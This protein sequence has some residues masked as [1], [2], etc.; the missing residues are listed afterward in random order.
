M[1]GRKRERQQDEAAPEGRYGWMTAAGAESPPPARWAP[2]TEAGTPAVDTQPDERG[3]DGRG[4]DEPGS[5]ERGQ[6]TPFWKRDLSLGRKPAAP[7]PERKRRGRKEERGDETDRTPFWKR[8][9]SLVRTRRADADADAPAP[10]RRPKRRRHEQPSKGARRHKQLV[11][12]K[13]GGSQLAAARVVNNGGVEVTQLAREALEPGVIVGGEVRDPEALAEALKE[14]FDRHKLPKRN[15]RLGL[16]NNRIG[17]RTLEIVG[18]EDPKQ[19][20]NAIRFR[21]QEVLPIAIE[22][23]VLDYQVL[24]EST[25]DGESVRR[26]LLVV[27]YR[28]LVDRYVDACRRAGLRLAGIDLEAFALLRAL[29]G[30]RDGEAGDQSALVAVA[31]GHDRTTLAVSDGRTCEFTRVLEWGGYALNVA[32]ARALEVT[33]AEAEPLKRALSLHGSDAVEGLTPEQ[34]EAAREAMRKQ[35]NVFARELVSSLQFYQGQPSSLPIAAITL[36]GGTAHLAGLAQ[37]L[38]RLIG[39]PVEVGDPL[40]RA[41]L[42]KKVREDE[43]LG[44]LAIAIGLGIED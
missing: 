40:A 6:R 37:E 28:E 27:A 24:D 26:I 3:P 42:G 32:V 43:Q 8:D 14:F 25:V 17:V 4:P 11:G 10:S 9:L 29:G 1:L 13:I 30:S 23:T 5:D 20:A 41:V 18:I 19:L 36:T 34:A 12:L 16:A 33:V 38:R 35:V 22:E 2:P 39:V 15:V 21:A 7:K 44:S 31:V